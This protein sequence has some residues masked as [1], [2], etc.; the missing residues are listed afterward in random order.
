MRTRVIDL[1]CHM[2]FDV[3]DGPATLDESVEM[4]RVATGSGIRIAV[5]TPHVRSAADAQPGLFA[6]R[7]LALNRALREQQIFMV[8]LTGAE[9]TAVAATEIGD[10]MMDNLT[11]GNSR[12]VLVEPPDQDYRLL[13]EAV[14]TLQLRGYR[15]AIAHPER[16]RLFQ[17]DPDLLEHINARDV[18]H[19]VTAGSLTGDFGRKAKKLAS[20][21]LKAEMVTALCSDAHDPKRRAPDIDK[22]K[23]AVPGPADRFETLTSTNPGSL[24]AASGTNNN[25]GSGVAA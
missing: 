16:C 5:S 23:K 1:H 11:L 3:D 9:V 20:H 15:V 22:A 21:M 7:A 25:G 19:V 12:T 10:E 14:F 17:R 6:E 18:A 8:V 13:D 24:L 2:L 4:A